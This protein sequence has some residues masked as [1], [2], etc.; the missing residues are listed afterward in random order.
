MDKI[1]EK[2]ATE[3]LETYKNGMPVKKVIVNDFINDYSIKWNTF[4]N[5]KLLRGLCFLFRNKNL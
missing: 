3:F 5:I 2:L 4:R 1:K